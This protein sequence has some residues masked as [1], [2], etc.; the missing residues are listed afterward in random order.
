MKLIRIDIQNFRGISSASIN[1]ENFTTLIGSNNIGKSTILKAIKILVDTTNPTSEDWPY[2]TASTD[3]MVI[4][5]IFS[6]I[7]D[8]ERA[9]PAISNLVHEGKL[10]IRVRTKWDHDNDCMGVP[11]Y[12]AFY[13][14]EDI[15]DY[16]SSITAA[17]SIPW[18][19]EI[20]NE[21]D[22]NNAKSY[23]DMQ[24]DVIGL[25]KQRY[26]EKV[27]SS[28]C[29]TSDGINFKNSLQQA[30]PHVLYIP[31]C[32][33]IEDDLKS[34]KGTPFGFLFSNRVYPVLQSDPSFTQYTSSLDLLHKKMKGEVDGEVIE[35]LHELMESITESLNQVM[36]LKSK[37]KLSL[38]EIDIN[39]ALM[40][41]ATLV[42]EDKLETQLEYQGSGVQ[43]ALAYALLESNA[44]FEVTSSQRS[45]IILYEEP[46]LYIHPHLM[47]L[48]RDKLREKS[49]NASCQVIVSTHS[50]F[51]IDIAENPSSLKLIKDTNEGTRTVH[52]IDDT[53]FHVD[54][55]YDEREMLRAALDFHPTVCEAFFAKRV[56]VVEGD[57]EVAILRFASDLCEKFGISTELVKDTTIV[58]AGGK[59]TI[60]A[61]ARILSKLNIPFKIVHDT[62]RKGMTEE[63]IN[64]ISAI[65][66]YRANAK[67]ENI[68][69]ADRVFRVDDTFEHLLWDPIIDG[70]APSDGGKPFNAWKRV[71]AYLDGTITLNAVCENKLRA[72]I[73]F[74]YG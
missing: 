62:D 5:G 55:S 2:R 60:P 22:C 36:D 71:R 63:Q 61:I 18:L 14:K 17:R 67:I 58:S 40:K 68:V 35:G 59:W 37:V 41:A 13:S 10:S 12:E 74:I 29:W 44:L 31:A 64:Q 28:L 19:L 1:L 27:S 70:N 72:V 48:L 73:Q 65:N 26:P 38:T 57:T 9:K 24:S 25:I 46:E 42:I 52:E 45:T 50:P 34:Q 39:A 30:L 54:E 15:E 49:T 20:I 3:E 7:Q 56:I 6:D 33:K 32:F 4:T 43:R 66:A 51:L 69:G 11:T 47:R 53:I 16:T 21:L 8:T 23:K